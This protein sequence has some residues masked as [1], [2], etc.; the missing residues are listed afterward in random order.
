MIPSIFA[1]KQRQV[2][3][4]QLIFHQ[5]INAW[6][7]NI[8][9]GG[10]IPKTCGQGPVSHLGIIEGGTHFPLIIANFGV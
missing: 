1:H 5:W 6:V 2:K 7:R 9:L 8:Q 3:G 10:L 4:V